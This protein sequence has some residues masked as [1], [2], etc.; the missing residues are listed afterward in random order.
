[1]SKS[2][3]EVQRERYKKVLTEIERTGGISFWERVERANIAGTIRSYPT[4]P[5]R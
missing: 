4:K 2:E 1:M 3:Y 5:R